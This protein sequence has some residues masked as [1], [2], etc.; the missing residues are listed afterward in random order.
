MIKDLSQEKVR[1][2]LN[3]L[4]RCHKE[5][6]TKSEQ[7][8]LQNLFLIFLILR[9]DFLILRGVSILNGVLQS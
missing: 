7:I 4:I 5:P 2:I 9:G 6:C 1:R 8:N 3:I